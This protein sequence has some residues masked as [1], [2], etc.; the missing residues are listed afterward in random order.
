MFQHAKLIWITYTTAIALLLSRMIDE[1]L[2]LQLERDLEASAIGDDFS[3]SE[4]GIYENLQ[5]PQRIDESN[6]DHDLEILQNNEILS[7]IDLSMDQTF[8]YAEKNQE[9]QLHHS[10][11]I[12]CPDVLM[13]E[14]SELAIHESVT[15]LLNDLLDSVEYLATVFVYPSIPLREIVVEEFVLNGL[16]GLSPLSPDTE[17]EVIIEELVDTA[18]FAETVGSQL[19][20]ESNRQKVHFQQIE[21]DDEL[22]L[23]GAFDETQMWFREKQSQI[24][25]RKLRREIESKRLHVARCAVSLSFF[26]LW[27]LFY[28]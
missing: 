7:K 13:D 15:D 2:Y 22:N 10:L 26:L 23:K 5:S 12:S 11:S 17:N 24:S 20:K 4:D 8:S 25:D 3:E 19:Q 9:Y 14:T 16:E 1:E 6:F 21:N 27:L 28:F 18:S